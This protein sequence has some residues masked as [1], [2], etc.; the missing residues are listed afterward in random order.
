MQGDL[1]GAQLTFNVTKMSHFQKSQVPSHTRTKK[2][3]RKMALAVATAVIVT[4]IL[5]SSLLHATPA[6]I[7]TSSATMF[8]S[9][10]HRLEV[11]SGPIVLNSKGCYLTGFEVPEGS[12]NAV[13]QGN[14]TLVNNATS[15]E[16]TILTVWSQ[17]EFLNYFS[18]CNAEPSYNKNLMPMLQDNLN[19]SLS[20]GYY[21]IMISGAGTQN[22]I[23]EAELI[24]SFAI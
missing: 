18:N 3:W 1:Y 2:Y 9:G 20:K 23:L 10:S 15:H 24:L 8:F 16:A 11:L 13:L 12:K 4:V 22:A 19:V 17:Q 6:T 5:T 14:Y 21:L 7:Q